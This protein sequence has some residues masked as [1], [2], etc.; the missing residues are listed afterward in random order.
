[1]S[2]IFFPIRLVY[3][4]EHLKGRAFSLGHQLADTLVFLPFHWWKSMESMWFFLEKVRR[5]S[6]KKRKEGCMLLL[7][8][9]LSFFI[10]CFFLSG[11]NFEQFLCTL[12]K[13]QLRWQTCVIKKRDVWWD[14]AIQSNACTS[15]ATFKTLGSLQWWL[16][17]IPNASTVVLAIF[18]F[19]ERRSS[20]SNL[21]GGAVADTWNKATSEKSKSLPKDRYPKIHRNHETNSEWVLLAGRRT[22][23][24]EFGD[25]KSKIESCCYDR[26]LITLW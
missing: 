7:F 13:K 20:H 26:D 11:L 6:L 1:M 2:F 24:S 25:E 14:E 16:I 23:V 3:L 15:W 5:D 12:K 18:F 4:R 8:Y 17:K 9:F 10:K 19:K 22:A 21:F